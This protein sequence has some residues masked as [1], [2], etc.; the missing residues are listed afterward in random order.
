MTA[1][2]LRDAGWTVLRFWE[3]VPTEVV[4]DSIVEVLRRSAD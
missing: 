1:A 3:H 2:A 4:V